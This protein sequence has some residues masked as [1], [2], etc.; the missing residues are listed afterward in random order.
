MKHTTVDDYWL[1]QISGCKHI[2]NL[3]AYLQN[4]VL[5]YLP[6]FFQTHPEYKYEDCLF[7]NPT[8]QDIVNDLKLSMVLSDQVLNVIKRL[9]NQEPYICDDRAIMASHS[10]GNMTDEQ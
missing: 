10:V 6:R 4:L 5:Q 7:L 3:P 9:P 8:Y 2:N 1:H